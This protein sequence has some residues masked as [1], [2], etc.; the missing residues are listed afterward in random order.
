M[1]KNKLKEFHNNFEF[2][3][4]QRQA[5]YL[6]SIKAITKEGIEVRY[7]EDG[8]YILEVESEYISSAEV[9]LREYYD[10]VLSPAISYIF[11][12]G[13]PTPKVLAN[14]TVNHPAGIGITVANPASYKIDEKQFGKVYSCIE[15][16]GMLVYKT[17]KYII[18]VS[19][20]N[21]SSEVSE[22]LEMQIFFR[23]FKDQLQR[24]L[25]IHRGIWEEI[26]S[27]KERHFIKG[28]EV[29]NLRSKLDAY[30]T[31]I[32][33]I[34]NRINQMGIYVNT[35]SSI[36]KKLEIETKLVE[37]FEYKFEVL[38]DSLSY[39]KEI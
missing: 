32:S 20:T 24:Y 14:I 28:K 36:A 10:R 31:S 34:K 19:K 4:V 12:K 16:K 13:A 5:G 33:L 9:Q 23:E 18:A 15:S 2:V 11:S 1:D 17:P 29:N 22:L 35:R 3:S 25:N 6:E 38:S 30:Q 26:S 8:L 7:Y 37:L 21:L 39:I 27:I